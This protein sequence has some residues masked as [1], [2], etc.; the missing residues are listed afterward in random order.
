MMVEAGV[1]LGNIGYVVCLIRYK[2]LC[3]CASSVNCLF[4]ANNNFPDASS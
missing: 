2:L 4:D 3:S 1:S